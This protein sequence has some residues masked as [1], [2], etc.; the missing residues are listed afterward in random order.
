[1]EATLAFLRQQRASVAA[2]LEG[3]RL[4]G[5][6]RLDHM[7]E[8]L[9]S[10]YGFALYARRPIREAMQ[11]PVLH[12]VLGSPIPDVLD[13]MISR[14][15]DSFHDDILLVDREGCF[16]GF[17]A[18]Q[19]LVQL[20]NELLHHK[21][22]ELA[23]ARDSAL[24]AARAKSAF[25]A[26]MS[27]EIRTPMNGVIGMANLLLS[28]PLTAEQQDLTQTLCQSGDSLLTVINDILDFS[29]VEGGY[30]MLEK[31]DFNLAEQLHHAVDLQSDTASRKGL[32]LVLEISA[33]VPVRMRGDP[34]RLR[35]VVLNLLGNA[36]KFTAQG[37][38]VLRVTLGGAS[39]SGHT[40][41][42]EVTDT[43]IGIEPAVQAALFQP[44]VQADTSTT[45]RFG[46]TG[47]GLAICRRLVE[48]M[49]GEI[50]V[51]S[52]P[53][54]GSTFWFTAELEPTGTPASAPA[55]T[56]AFP[57]RRRVLIV[58]DNATNRKWLAHLCRNWGLSHETADGAPAAMRWLQRARDERCPFDAVLLDFQMPGTDGLG[59]ARAIQAD[60]S[61]PP[62][63]LILLTSRGERLSAAQIAE[64]GLD[65]CELKPIQHE[66]L[67]GTLAR[68]LHAVRNERAKPVEAAPASAVATC[69]DVRI[70]LAEDN[71]VNQKVTVLQLRR[72][73]YTADVVANGKQVLEA[74]RGRSYD[75]VLMDQQMPEMDGLE[76]TRRIRLAPP[77]GDLPREIPIIA[78]TANA[79]IGDRDVCLDAGMND[80][81]A[82][83]VRPEDLRSMLARYIPERVG[84]GL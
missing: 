31:I 69:A 68:A 45:R 32:E 56:P 39:D 50:G 9:A 34:G 40:L 55:A 70:L 7:D 36:V 8:M 51:T 22:D 1:M 65:A 49:H 37:E 82:K 15:L 11:P 20:Q 48:L 38:V 42:F 30:L 75:L 59:L 2:V 64:H 44:F 46:G 29:K 10:R 4:L 62:P 16:V 35:Q 57:G 79:M 84:V 3:G 78:M 77:E 14:E 21:L 83:P 26:N 71:P 6:V 67:R 61:L 28:T 47:L 80:Y 18:V 54:A 58:D 19:R 43:G 60:Y 25:L 52:T 33:E 74:L 17:I 81:L 23:A 41:R 24:A 66:R 12:V 73:G 53:G 63:A 5:V 13:T 76:A 27:H 72:L